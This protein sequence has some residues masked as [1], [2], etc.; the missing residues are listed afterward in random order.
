MGINTSF[1]RRRFLTGAAATAAFG[2]SILRA[3]PAEKRL[4]IAFIGYG[5]RAYAVMGQAL[6][7]KD[8]RIGAGCEVEGTRRAKAKEVVEKAYA[9][10]IK[11]G[12][13]KGCDVYVDYRELV[14][15]DDLDAVVIMTPDHMHVHPALAAAAKGL[16]IYCEKPLT[17]NI[18]E[19][20]VLVNAVKRNKIIFQTGS[21]QRCEFEGRFRKAAE[22]IRAGALGDL[23]TIRIGVGESPK[24]CDLPAQ[25]QPEDVNWDLWLGPAPQRAYNE[26]LCPKGVHNHYPA[27]RHY[28][29]YSGG[30]L[31]DIGAHHFDIAQWAMGMDGS[32]P[33]TVEPPAEG[34]TGLKF[35][36]ASGVEMFHGGPSGC[37]FEGTKGTLRV[38]R[39]ILETEPAELL[40]TPIGNRDGGAGGAPKPWPTNHLRNWI[41]CVKSRE[42]PICTAET[43]HRTA[44]VCHLANIGY[45]LRRKL[46]WDPE[47]EQFVNDAEA[48]ALT[49]RK[50]RKGWA[51]A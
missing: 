2:P 12:E 7:E 23:K 29:E 50:A 44:T 22:L 10:G 13:Y 3:A 37:T 19:G 24:P 30:M 14:K 48:N 16:D 4:N 39:N 33:V 18:A 6:R 35:T 32:G 45:K 5:K 51:Y 15:R 49:T 17:Q 31:A 40:E 34:G 42:Q 47:K 25:E 21:Q 20:R 36:Y 26:I 9:E 38:D 1:S 41:D 28:E 11:A 8:V 46:T 43:G 27:F